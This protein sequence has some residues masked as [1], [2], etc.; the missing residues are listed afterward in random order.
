MRRTKD[1]CGFTLL[2]IVV[3]IAILALIA[4]MISRIFSESTRAVERG[5]DDAL[6]DESARL[7]LDV[8]EEDISQALVRTNVAFRIE[9]NNAAIY[10]IS[11]GVRRQLERILRDTAPM[12]IEF[13]G[14]G[15][16]SG[17]L[18]I[19]APDQ[20]TDNTPDE[21]IL[22]SEYYTDTPQTDFNNDTMPSGYTEYTE[23]YSGSTASQ[24]VLTHLAFV[25]NGDPDWRGG[26]PLGDSIERPRFVDVTLGL[27]SSAD[28]QLANLENSDQPIRANERIYARR[29]FLRNTGTGF[30][31]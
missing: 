18:R 29:I 21:A 11:T 28:V 17:T 1:R 31:Q 3:S 24:A 7:L 2:E 13:S 5:K 4:L 30:L 12:R 19:T 15:G 9:N 25:V 27:A 10:F 14:N 8:M 22:L 20:G 6:L 26:N 23:P 16:F